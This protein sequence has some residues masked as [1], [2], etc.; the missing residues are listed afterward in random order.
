MLKIIVVFYK[1]FFVLFIKKRKRNIDKI[2]TVL[3]MIN[4]KYE[5]I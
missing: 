1:I 2:K 5:K 3:D 4:D